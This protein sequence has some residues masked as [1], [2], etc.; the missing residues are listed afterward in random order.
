MYR[1]FF[2]SSVLFAA[3]YSTTGHSHDLVRISAQGHICIV[4]SNFVIGETRH[5]LADLKSGA[6]PDLEQIL[7]SAFIEVIHVDK[8]EIAAAAQHIVLKDA[9]I[10]AQPKPPEWICS[11]RWIGS[12]SWAAPNSQI[13]SGRRFYPR[14]R[15]SSASGG[16]DIHYGI[17]LVPF[18]EFGPP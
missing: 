11:S 13:T 9:P 7:S 6:L 5:N 10:L 18:G 1:V 4:L 2:D 12:T 16:N 17:E 8:V 3:A 15:R 14:K